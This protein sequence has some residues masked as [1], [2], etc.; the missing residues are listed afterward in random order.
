MQ[1]IH[2]YEYHCACLRHF[3]L[4]VLRRHWWHLNKC[5]QHM[6][7]FCSC[8]SSMKDACQKYLPS[9]VMDR[10]VLD[11]VS[12]CSLCKI[13]DNSIDTL[14]AAWYINTLVKTHA[15]TSVHT[16]YDTNAHVGTSFSRVLFWGFSVQVLFS[17]FRSAHVCLSGSISS[18]VYLKV[19]CPAP[20][21]IL[22]NLHLSL[23]TL[24]YA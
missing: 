2:I 24:T 10:G 12:S 14:A 19:A 11:V 16:S 21:F 17:R 18:Y 8:V 3:G 15:D 13:A 20:S 1:E 22:K 6:Q 5:K 7:T 4:A 23:N 9:W